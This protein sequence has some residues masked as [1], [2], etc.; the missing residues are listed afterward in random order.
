MT[1]KRDFK[2]KF[3]NRPLAYKYVV[4]YGNHHMFENLESI[5]YNN[6]GHTN[7]CLQIMSKA[8]GEYLKGN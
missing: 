3:I 5:L 1:C 4:I 8:Q 7:R 6:K 2:M